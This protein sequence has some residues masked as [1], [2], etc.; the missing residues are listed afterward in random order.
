MIP[1]TLKTTAPMREFQ[2]TI[3]SALITST[4][5]R[6]TY[7]TCERN[8]RWPSWITSAPRASSLYTGPG[9]P[10]SST[11]MHGSIAPFM[12]RVR[13]R[14]PI[15]MRVCALGLIP[16]EVLFVAGTHHLMV[17]G[18][19]HLVVVG[20]AALLAA[21]V[22]VGMSVWAARLNDGRAV[23]LGLAFS[24]MSVLLLVHA[25]ATPDVLIGS[26]GVV[27]VAGAL[28]LPIG[29]LILSGAGLPA[30]SGP[31]RIP[32]LQRAQVVILVCLVVMGALALVF[33]G[34][35]PVVPNPSSVAAETISSA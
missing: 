21:V 28:N 32:L 4:A 24:V 2:M 1:V 27:Q 17:P 5:T 10:G 26:N 15:L 7:E 11:P 16:A 18:A 23:L 13:R 29:G 14:L 9:S 31:E 6:S 19:V 8:D 12:S 30:F 20:T 34:Q 25:L 33:A 3:I 22:A 35:I